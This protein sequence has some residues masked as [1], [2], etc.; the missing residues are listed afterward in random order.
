M[1]CE[2]DII[3]YKCTIVSNIEAL[4]LLW[5]VT[6]PDLRHIEVRYDNT[7]SLVTVHSLGYNITTVLI[8]YSRSDGHIESTIHLPIQRGIVATGTGVM[9]GI[10]LY[11]DVI[12][13][14][15]EILAIAGEF[16]ISRSPLRK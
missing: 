11:D 16:L 12:A 10:Q 9:C 6:L 7:S 8:S 4:H 1:E 13:M 3:S 2:S 15:T 5:Y 14:E